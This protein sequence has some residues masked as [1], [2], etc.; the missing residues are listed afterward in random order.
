MTHLDTMIPA[1]HDSLNLGFD[2]AR[3]IAVHICLWKQEY[4]FIQNIN[5]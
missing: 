2:S 1:E 3:P 4:E 5:K